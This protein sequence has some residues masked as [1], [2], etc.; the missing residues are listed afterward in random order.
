M[1]VCIIFNDVIGKEKANKFKNKNI[2]LNFC[3]MKILMLSLPENFPLIANLDIY[4]SP[5][6]LV[7]GKN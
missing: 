1:T 5:C 2:S 7:Y 3:L 4:F 6:F